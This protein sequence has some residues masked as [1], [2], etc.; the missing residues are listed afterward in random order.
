MAGSFTRILIGCVLT[1]PTTGG[2]FSVS[3]EALWWSS[4]ERVC[5]CKGLICL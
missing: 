1:P 5:V 2:V 4:D 3:H